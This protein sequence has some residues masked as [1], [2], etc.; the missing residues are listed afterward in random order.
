MQHTPPFLSVI[1]ATFNSAQ[2]LERTFQSLLN[3]QYKEFEYIVIDGSSK[4]G[5]RDI[6]MRYEGVFNDNGISFQW[7]S[8]VDSGIYDAWNKG[9][10][11]AKGKWI[12][13]LGSDDYYVE[14]A[15]TIYAEVLLSNPDTDLV[16]GNVQVMNVDEKVKIIDGEWSWN[17]FKRHMNI[18]H[19][20]SFHNN[21][22]FKKFGVFDP[23]YKIA[24]DYEL[25]LRKKDKLQTYH[26]NEVLAI[27]SEG[28]VS[29][30]QIN[31]VLKETAYAKNKTA[32]LTKSICFMDRLIARIKYSVKKM[33]D[34]FTG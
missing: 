10:K 4:D 5:T 17:T 11:L 12:S 30:N 1:T 2:T 24:G 26:I 23:F 21:Q 22:Y 9:L 27:M 31:R 3:Q 18:A 6:I 8:E 20:G 15:L 19:V 29:N 14:N 13:F 7:I 25:L 28:G 32:G 16:Y 33:I 34:A